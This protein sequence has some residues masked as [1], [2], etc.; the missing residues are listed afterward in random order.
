MGSGDDKVKQGLTGHLLIRN[1][2]YFDYC[3]KEAIASIIDICDEFIILE[4]HSDKDDTYDHCMA[5]KDKYHPKLRVIRGEWEGNESPGLSFG[6]T[7]VL[8]L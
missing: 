7:K 2:N 3:W 5:L 6:N 8:L 1:G 4:A